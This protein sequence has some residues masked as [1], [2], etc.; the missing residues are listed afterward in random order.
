MNVFKYKVLHCL[1]VSI[2]SLFG[3]FLYICCAIVKLIVFLFDRSDTNHIKYQ[4]ILNTSKLQQKI[5]KHIHI[6]YTTYY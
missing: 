2:D 3:C 6:K 5:K 4:N 1:T